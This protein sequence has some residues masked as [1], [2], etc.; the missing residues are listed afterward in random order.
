M[1]LFKRKQPFNLKA[2][3]MLSLTLSLVAC[4]G[5]TTNN[6]I[7]APTPTPIVED[8]KKIFLIGD[9][10]VHHE[11]DGYDGWGEHLG[12]FM[13]HSG[14]VSNLAVSGESSRSYKEKVYPDLPGVNPKVTGTYWDKKFLPALGENNTG[15]LLIQFGH[16]DQLADEDFFSQPGKGNTYYENLK[17][18]VDY[19]K[20][21][22]L[23]PVLV[24][25]V[26][27]LYKDGEKSHAN[28]PM[29]MSDL[30]KDEKVLLLDLNNKSFIEFNKYPDVASLRKIFAVKDDTDKTHFNAKG[31][32]IIAGWIKALACDLTDKKLCKQF[33]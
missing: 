21:K 1:F 32:K 11:Q 22:G 29:T 27:R 2:L 18:Y 23:T 7:P 4:G 14:N 3:V 8:N 16:N 12:S 9:S 10:S 28:Y 19:A 15:F 25:S 6:P 33:K 24:T 13:K 30:A 31:A 5:G 20:G 17:F 26:E